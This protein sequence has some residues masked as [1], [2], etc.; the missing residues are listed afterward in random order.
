MPLYMTQV[1]YT[2]QAWA[3]LIKTPQN[4]IEIVRPVLRKL[5]GDIETAY[6]AFGEHDVIGVMTL[7]SNVE[8]AAF[9]LAVTAGGAVKSIKTTPLMTIEEGIGAMQKASTSGYVPATAAG[10]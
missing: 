5:G 9:S 4:R 7:P 10:V 2:P 6:F 3:A 8:A 1:A